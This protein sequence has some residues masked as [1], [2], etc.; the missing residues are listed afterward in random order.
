MGSVCIQEGD[1]VLIFTGR[2]IISSFVPPDSFHHTY[3]YNTM[4][5]TVSTLMQIVFTIHTAWLVYVCVSCTTGH[6]NV[7]SMPLCSLA[8]MQCIQL[9]CTYVLDKSWPI[10]TYTEIKRD[11][12]GRVA[13]E[14]EWFISHTY[15]IWA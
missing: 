7:Q 4:L 15:R 5:Q 6:E 3:I 12:R 9:V 13:P 1:K 8:I 10:G 14:G 11:T 2:K